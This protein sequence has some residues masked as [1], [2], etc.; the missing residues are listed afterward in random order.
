MVDKQHLDANSKPVNQ[1]RPAFPDHQGTSANDTCFLN[2]E[3]KCENGQ[4][5]LILTDAKQY[6]AVRV[7]SVGQRFPNNVYYALNVSL[8]KSVTVNVLY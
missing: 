6:K 4:G 1:R 2:A 8:W 5:E 3:K 7:N